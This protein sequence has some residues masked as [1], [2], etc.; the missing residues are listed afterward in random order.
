MRFVGAIKTSAGMCCQEHVKGVNRHQ[1]K[2]RVKK[3]E[4]KV[5]EAAARLLGNR[6]PRLKGKVQGLV[7]A[8]QAK[9][10][11]VRQSGRTLGAG[12]ICPSGIVGATG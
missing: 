7:G 12:V 6:K 2:G 5:M 8:A 9:L 11:D 10:G 4:G 1:V 3:V